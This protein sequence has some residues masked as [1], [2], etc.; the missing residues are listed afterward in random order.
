[1]FFKILPSSLWKLLL[2]AAMVPEEKSN[3]IYTY[4]IF[5]SFVGVKWFIDTNQKECHKKLLVISFLFYT[6][7]T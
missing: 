3:M 5:P 6:I 2:I 1:M 7:Y 4:I